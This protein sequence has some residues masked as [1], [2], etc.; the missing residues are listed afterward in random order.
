VQLEDVSLREAVTALA[1]A[2]NARVQ[3]QSELLNAVHNNVTLHA[4]NMALGAAFEAVLAGTRLRAVPLARDA[5]S[6]QPSSTVDSVGTG[7]IVGHVTDG[8]TERPVRNARVSIDGT[9]HSVLTQSDGSFHFTGIAT[10]THHVTVRRIGYQVYSEAVAV[11]AGAATTMHAVLS[12]AA[13]RLN[14]IVT[15]AVGDQRRLEVGNVIAHLNVDSIAKTAPVNSLTDLLSA[16]AAGVQIVE[17]NGLVGSGPVIR[18]RGQSSL[19]ATRDPIIIVDGIRQDNTPGNT[20][21][22]LHG[23]SVPSPSRINDLDLSQIET[24]D[25]LKGPAASTEYGTDAA[26]GVIVITTKRGKAGET[27][28]HVSGEHGWSEIPKGWED[29]YY[30]F[31]HLPDGTPVMCPRISQYNGAPSVL[32]G[33]CVVDSVVHD[34][35]LNH[36]AT[37]LFGQGAR[38]RYNIDVS[39]G[40]NTMRYFLGAGQSG[41]L[42]TLQIP[43]VFRSEALTYGFPSAALNPSTLSQ[44]SL[45]TNFLAEIGKTA[46][47]AFHGSYMATRQRTTDAVGLFEGLPSA[48]PVL[49]SAHYY[50]YGGYAFV[51]P[52]ADLGRIQMEATKRTTGGV[53]GNWR[54]LDWFSARGTVGLDHGSQISKGTFLPQA[55]YYGYGHPDQGSLAITNSTTDV[56]SA[57]LRAVATVPVTDELRSVTSVGL[58]MANTRT[59][60]ITAETSGA[61][62]ETNLTLNGAPNPSVSQAGTGHATVGGYLEQEVSL[63]E[64]L[65]VTGAIRVDGA[66]GF[67]GDYH[68][69][70]YPKLSVSWLALNHGAT[71]IRLRG[72]FGA[73]GVQ[74]GN[75]AALQLYRV[76]TAYLNGQAFPASAFSTPGNPVLKPERSQEFEGGV[77]V[78]LWDNRVNIE[79]TQYVK[80]TK[81]A[82]VSSSLGWTLGYT[83]WQQNLGDV[84]NSGVE[85]M[86]QASLI[87]SN[88]VSL[89]VTLNASANRNKLLRLAPGIPT[90]CT[91]DQCN[92]VGYPLFGYWGNR[93][94]YADDNGDGHLDT[95]EVHAD[96]TTSYMGS[97]LP[98]VETSLSMHL[99]LFRSA[100]AFGALF[101]Y[102]AGGLIKNRSVRRAIAY[103]TLREQNDSLAPLWQQAE[104]LA[105]LRV[106]YPSLLFENGTFLRWRELSMTYTV[107]PRWLRTLHVHDLAVI[108]AVR[109]LA[110]WKRFTGQDPE[111]SEAGGGVGASVYDYTS[112]TYP[113][114]NDIRQMGNGAV[115]LPRTWVIRMNVGF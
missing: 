33:T 48:I 75:G 26:S 91:N 97:S 78:G 39:G 57:D 69:T 88:P 103:G 101:D 84:K 114:N 12:T 9:T 58:Q 41:D 24:I 92:A 87:Q 107:P 76:R 3:Y 18:I 105:Y 59:Q 37:T 80:H 99:S 110:L 21:S 96:R 17:A 98:K 31:G 68:T 4:R 38:D 63:S 28:W 67:G 19:V 6:I 104:L 54:P 42:G 64:Q 2:A 62:N 10:G 55:R 7:E 115:P 47:V 35:P 49:D 108:A 25:I 32:D 100:L 15:T 65:F 95:T 29:Y 74:P 106:N 82:L 36:R 73:A 50:G 111:V 27:R 60:G 11:S 44:Q 93:V 72:A 22:N 83:S 52:L 94:T 23:H 86:V 90:A 14:E 30:G 13:T 1:K 81:D 77:D 71:T 40:T 46:D 66:S 51:A 8:S 113:A 79:L 56:S 45:R 70:A 43:D 5:I 61:L 34:N 89:D 102:R 53:T 109:N 112:G 16:R 20:V 85:A